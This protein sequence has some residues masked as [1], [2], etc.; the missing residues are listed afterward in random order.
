MKQKRSNRKEENETEYTNETT[1][2]RDR[3]T[4][5]ITKLYS[6]CAFETPNLDNY[7]HLS[8]FM[9]SRTMRVN[10]LLLTQFYPYCAFETPNLEN[11]MYLSIFMFLR[12]IHISCF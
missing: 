8:I 7:L 11:Y 9:L 2:P 5:K 6:Q 10:F 12:A 1:R 3:E 4:E